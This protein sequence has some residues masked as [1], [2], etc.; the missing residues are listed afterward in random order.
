MA[1][2]SLQIGIPFAIAQL[3]D[4]VCNQTVLVFESERE[5]CLEAITTDQTSCSLN[6]HAEESG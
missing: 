3:M 5:V 1:K 2:V 6:R 4:F